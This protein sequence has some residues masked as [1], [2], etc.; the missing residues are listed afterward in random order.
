MP[1]EITID[2]VIATPWLYRPDG[3]VLERLEWWT[4]VIPSFNGQEQRIKLREFPRRSFEF[5]TL[6]TARE[7]RSAENLLHHW[8]AR[9]FALPVWMDSQTLSAG[10]T[11]G[12]TVIPIDTTTRD[13]AAGGWA[14]IATGPHDFELAQIDAVADDQ[15][16]LADP[17]ASA[18]PAGA[19]VFPLRAC[20]LPDEVRLSR[21]TGDTSYGRLRFEC[22]GNSAWPAATGGTA[23]R[24]FPVLTQAPNWVE[25]VEQPYLR[26]LA[27][28]DAGTGGLF[29]D[30]Q[31]S[32]A[33][34][35]QSHRWLLDGRAEIDAFRRW[36]Y[37]RQGRLASFWLPSFALD[38][39][40]V[41]VI[42]A[43]DTTIDVEHCGYTATVA[44][45][46]GR[47][48]IRIELHDGTT[49]FRRVTDCSVVSPEVERITINAA[50]GAEVEPDQI[51]SVSFCDLVRLD[52]DAVEI[53]WWRWDAA[54]SRL[55]TRGSRN[56]L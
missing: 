10:L 16:T 41:D 55:M 38:L 53:A 31:G 15:L 13:F 35:M 39:R 43:A 48:D 7:R 9:P 36:L 6:L 24:G 42:D 49:Y 56:D 30:E 11:A 23:Y 14:G 54:E 3:M 47:R 26:K 19:E 44:E 8:Q 37:A 20:I 21:F 51:R 52:G 17:L 18:W 25:D 45:D 4:D 22:I 50:L 29:V 46:I 32:G 33:V 40:V 2:G 12:A 27:I 1:A 28:L 34:L 5:G